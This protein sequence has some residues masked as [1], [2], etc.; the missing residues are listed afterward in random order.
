MAL[1]LTTRGLTKRYGDTTVLQP[2]DLDLREGEVLG[3]L[4]PNGAGKTTTIRC[5][6]GL[7]R[8]TAGTVE[9]FGTDAAA[10]PA[11]AHRRLAYVP[12]EANLWPRLTGEETLHLL[13]RVH[14]NPDTAYRDELVERRSG[15][16]RGGPLVVP[17]GGRG[18]EPRGRGLDPADRGA[19]P[20]GPGAGGTR[21]LDRDRL[22]A[23]ARGCRGGCRHGGV[24]APRRPGR[25]T[26]ADPQC[27]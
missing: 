26:A 2:L 9:V 7:V 14:G 15:P 1:A 13:G 17:R 10:H 27:W 25:L 18:V 8:P 16:L 6:L 12:G 20:R 3:Y 24:P 4:G 23:R 11:E 5:V 21:R 19:V 22:A